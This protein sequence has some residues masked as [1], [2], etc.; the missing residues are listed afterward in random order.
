MSGEHSHFQEDLRQMKKQASP[1]AS[2][3]PAWNARWVPAGTGSE[4]HVEKQASDLLRKMRSIHSTPP[5]MERQRTPTLFHKESLRWPHSR[6]WRQ[7]SGLPGAGLQAWRATGTWRRE[8]GPA[9]PH[10]LGAFPAFPW[11]Q[12]H[13]VLTLGQPLYLAMLGDTLHLSFCF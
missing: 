2:S 8:A 6:P 7:W 10:C 11:L 1:L 4:E 5:L 13:V 3:V 12:D 9:F